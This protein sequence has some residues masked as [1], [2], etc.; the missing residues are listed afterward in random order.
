MAVFNN[1]S[2]STI[3]NPNFAFADFISG[4]HT[5]ENSLGD[6][7][8]LITTQTPYFQSNP[9]GSFSA[10]W[11]DSKQTY[12]WGEGSYSDST[13]IATLKMFE[14]GNN[15]GLDIGISGGN[16]KID[17][18]TG[19]VSSAITAKEVWIDSADGYSIAYHGTL[20]LDVETGTVSGS[21]KD[22][23]MACDNGDPN[24]E[25]SYY[26]KL[27]GSVT[28]D[29]NG[30]FSAGNVTGIEWGS[31]N[32]NTENPVF[33]VTNKITGIKIDATVI[34]D[35]L[36]A[37]DFS[38]LMSLAY[39]GND[40]LT[41]TVGSDFL[42][43][44]A[45]NDKIDGG[46]G[47]DVIVGGAGNDTIIG[48]AGDDR[49]FGDTQD[50]ATNASLTICN[51]TIT[52]LSGNNFVFAAGG[53][54]TVNVG[55][56]NDWVQA[57]KGDDKI[58]VGG[59]NDAATRFSLAEEATSNPQ[60]Y[61]DDYFGDLAFHNVVLAGLG[62]NTITA[63]NGNDYITTD[64]DYF[65]SYDVVNSTYVYAKTG[66]SNTVDGNNKITA[67]DGYNVIQ[68]GDG[69][70]TIT[71]GSTTSA[72]DTE[73]WLN[74]IFAGNGNN[75]ITT[76]GSGDDLVVAGN[77]NNTITVGGGFNE[78]HV[79]TGNNKITA[80]DGG[81]RIGVGDESAFLAYQDSNGVIKGNGNNTITTGAGSDEVWAWEGNDVAKLGTGSD[82]ADLGA[83]KNTIDLG[84]DTA[85]DSVYFGSD[86]LW[87]AT[88]G[89]AKT[90][91][92]NTVSNFNNSDEL[93]F[94]LEFEEAL[95][96]E[97]IKIGKDA[98]ITE[99]NYHLVFNTS[100]GKLYYD[101]DGTGTGEA[102][103]QIG[104]IKGAGLNGVFDITVDGNDLTIYSGSIPL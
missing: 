42:D 17:T 69:N 44:G 89:N 31:V 24:S 78:V 91:A 46:T 40:T 61:T 1:V 12:L 66:N 73:E 21:L 29:A 38:G 74:Q 47:D 37:A 57:G 82:W 28:M 101:A 56:G 33:S 62:N 20:K 53:K 11:N 86:F 13:G 45:G 36:D 15:T 3:F 70:N 9:D 41:G 65:A 16:I 75:K 43:A 18:N 98:G 77:G 25:A 64:D 8:N 88:D 92:L 23:Y 79:G 59:G 50:S 60:A 58:N 6:L 32:F 10:S 5:A 34:E 51:D 27:S 96:K 4:I 90:L 54:N 84:S 102:A 14:L 83:G 49:I 103:I 19:T 35:V 39:S 71:A 95:T 72:A 67:G 7:A 85:T 52:D 104:L 63:G 26:V 80:G 81:N 2:N 55:D 76:L 94:N 93:C 99:G 100:S 97:Q 68:V 87:A 22:V 30:N 48:G